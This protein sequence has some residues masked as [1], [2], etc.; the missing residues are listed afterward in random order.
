MAD[1]SDPPPARTQPARTQPGSDL[2]PTV[3]ERVVVDADLD[4]LWRTLTD[5][6][7]LG[8]WLGAEVDLAVAAGARGH[9]VDDDGTR[10]IV[11]VDEVVTGRRLRWRWRPTGGAGQLGTTDADDDVDAW[12][13]VEIEVAPVADGFEVCVTETPLPTAPAVASACAVVGG[14]DQAGRWTGRLLGLELRHLRHRRP[15]AIGA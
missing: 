7:E 14:R 2:R 5:G 13:V 15:V 9:V 1:R 8:R 6:D 12:S 4:D 11:E 10:R 3:T